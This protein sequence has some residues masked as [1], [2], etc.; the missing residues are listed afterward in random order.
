M[1][2]FWLLAIALLL[3]ALAVLTR[4][5]WRTAGAATPPRDA[6]R[7]NLEVLR[8]QLVQLDTNWPAAR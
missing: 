5:S 8:A 1:M 7:A 6:R 4:S 3:L 2:L